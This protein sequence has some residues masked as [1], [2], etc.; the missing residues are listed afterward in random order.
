MPAL[1]A[2]T[3]GHSLS[4]VVSLLVMRVPGR[5]RTWGP[6]H[7]ILSFH[8]PDVS[9][10]HRA[11]YWAWSTRFA[12]GPSGGTNYT[13]TQTLL[14]LSGGVPKSKSFCNF[15]ASRHNECSNYHLMHRFPVQP[16]QSLMFGPMGS[17][18]YQSTAAHTQKSG[19]DTVLS[20][21]LE[22]HS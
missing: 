9:H 14:I 12:S 3:L 13:Y 2:Q 1:G 8:A 15:K 5:G 16:L 11:Y 6:W 7:W 17:S 10:M 4:L 18:T 20:C 19:N 22:N 21:S